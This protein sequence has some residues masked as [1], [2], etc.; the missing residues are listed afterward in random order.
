M[1]KAKKNGNLAIWQFR[2]KEQQLS[3]I[4]KTRTAI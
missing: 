2:S 3:N 4:A 1:A